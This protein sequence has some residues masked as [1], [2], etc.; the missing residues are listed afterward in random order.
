[1][2]TSLKK[3]EPNS[4]EKETVME[5]HE[6]PNEE[7]AVQSQKICRRERDPPKKIRRRSPIQ[8][9]CSPW[10]NIKKSLKKPQ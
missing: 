3:I 5:R 7:V 8:E 4:G 9:R 1:M 6:I 2:E 10:R